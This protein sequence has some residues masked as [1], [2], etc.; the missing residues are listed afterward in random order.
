MEIKSTP[1]HA[2]ADSVSLKDLFLKLREWYFYLVGKWRLILIFAI[3]GA[4]L[5][6]AYAYVKKAEY[7][8]TTTFVLEA[9]DKAS[10]LGQYSGIASMI[11]ID[12]GIG[13]GGIFQGDNIL[14][15]Y[16]SRRM[17][18]E[19]LLTNVKFKGKTKS[20]VEAYIDI[21]D[22]RDKWSKKT[23][24]QTIT[25]STA[26]TRST[27]L[28][29]S[30]LNTVIEDIDK[31]YLKVTKIDQK[32]SIIKAEVKASDEGFAK[33]FNE[34]IVKNVNEFYINTKT[35]KALLNVAIL[36][37]KTDSVR[38]VMNNAIYS[39]AS[40]ADATPNLNV[41]R[42]VQRVAPVQRSQ[43][44][45]ETNKT[46][47][48]ELVKNLELSKISLL[49]ETP[50]IQVIDEPFLPLK[51]TRTGKVKAAIAGAFLSGFLVVFML[52]SR[53]LF[54]EMLNGGQI[55]PAQ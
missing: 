9:G 24:L 3:L 45:A 16:R 13:G 10:G 31:N 34:Q 7:T 1:S 37:L 4:V 23:K 18:R 54:K 40:V 46:I 55:E 51:K 32:L 8:A 42:Q 53:R 35:K 6:F 36:Q 17:L 50:L 15:L 29:D 5:G 2:D 19:T 41:T 26:A 38:A 28:H 47:L 12:I 49:N 48:G 52:L 33:A 22:L 20:L 27:R 39:A 21:N 14:E 43:F 11:G 25:F 30:I 44:S